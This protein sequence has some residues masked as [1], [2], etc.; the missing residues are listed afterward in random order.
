M[1]EQTQIAKQLGISMK[2][3]HRILYHSGLE[4]AERYELIN[5]KRHYQFEEVMQ[6]IRK[7]QEHVK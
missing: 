4:Q 3:L 6:V 2:A 1:T 7:G 5:G